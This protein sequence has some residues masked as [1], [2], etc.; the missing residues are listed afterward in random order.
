MDFCVSSMGLMYLG[1]F[2]CLVTSHNLSI[3]EFAMIHLRYTVQKIIQEHIKSTNF[4]FF[5][6]R[7]LI[8]KAAYF[9]SA[10]QLLTVTPLTS[11][12]A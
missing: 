7:I 10:S 3:E 2:L 8:R 9:H 6:S 5:S 1:F 12:T 4:I 11:V